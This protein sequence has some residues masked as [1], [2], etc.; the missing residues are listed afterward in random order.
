[1]E[2]LFQ[3]AIECR[4]IFVIELI[5]MVYTNTNNDEKKRFFRREAEDGRNPP[6]TTVASCSRHWTDPCAVMKMSR[7]YVIR[8]YY[9]PSRSK[10]AIDIKF[11]EQQLF[12]FTTSMKII[13]ICEH[14]WDLYVHL[15]V[16]VWLS[17]Q[18]ISTPEL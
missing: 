11:S 4:E 7:V 5:T 1:M 9:H 3:H 10:Y 13:I 14:C 2:F 16:S 8:Y 15:Y 17:K 6:C 12:A 18:T